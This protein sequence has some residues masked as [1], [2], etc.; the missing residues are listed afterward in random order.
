MVGLDIARTAN[1]HL[2]IGVAQSIA[3]LGGFMATLLVLATMGAVMTA[4]GGFTPEAFRVA[5]AGHVSGVGVRRRGHR[6]HP[7]PQGSPAVAPSTGRSGEPVTAR[8]QRA[9]VPLVRSDANSTM[10]VPSRPTAVARTPRGPFPLGGTDI[11]R[12]GL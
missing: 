8:L 1:P 9:A 12:S 2:N 6:R 4:A 5:L 7:P 10:Q 3:N 11:P